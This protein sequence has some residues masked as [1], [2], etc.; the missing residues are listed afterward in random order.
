MTNYKLLYF[1]CLLTLNS[2]LA[3]AQP[4]FLKYARQRHFGKSGV[5]FDVDGHMPANHQYSDADCITSTHETTHGVNAAIR[6]IMCKQ[7]FRVNCFY[8][9]DDRFVAID[10]PNITLTYVAQRLP[11][12]LRGSGYQ[13]YLV[14]QA[15][16]WNDCPLYIFDEWVSYCNGV[17]AGIEMQGQDNGRL[18]KTTEFLNYALMMTICAAGR[19]PSIDNENECKKFFMWYTERVMKL[20]QKAR[21]ANWNVDK[22]LAN[23]SLLQRSADCEQ[24]RSFCK[25]YYGTEFSQKWLGLSAN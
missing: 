6:M 8:V 17:D 14:Q 4:T 3:Y 21:T 2:S 25:T 22:A 10:E 9:L 13:L 20:L 5:F 7:R 18:D 12:S 16:G 11:W 1:V 19:H 15:G 23:L 24:L